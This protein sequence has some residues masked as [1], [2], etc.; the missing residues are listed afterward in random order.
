MLKSINDILDPKSKQNFDI[1]YNSLIKFLSGKFKNI[2]IHAQ[3]SDFVYIKNTAIATIDI[4]TIDNYI[5]TMDE[6][7][8]LRSWTTCRTLLESI[9]K[10]N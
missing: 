4:A 10:Q 1:N 8:F 2:V 9:K 3:K 6:E 5:R 7:E